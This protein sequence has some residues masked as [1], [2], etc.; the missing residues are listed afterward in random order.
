MEQ[1]HLLVG[2]KRAALAACA[3]TGTSC[4]SLGAGDTAVHGVFW[5]SSS[6]VGVS[7]QLGGSPSWIQDSGTVL[8]ATPV[9]VEVVSR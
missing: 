1:T 2:L 5:G 4:F 6:W 8:F 9:T 7:L 3:P